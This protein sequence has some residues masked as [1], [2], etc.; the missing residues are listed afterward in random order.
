MVVGSSSWIFVTLG[1]CWKIT[2]GYLRTAS[3]P[4]VASSQLPGGDVSVLGSI[5]TVVIPRGD[6]SHSQSYKDIT[7]S[8]N[9][10]QLRPRSWLIPRT[11]FDCGVLMAPPLPPL[12]PSNLTSFLTLVL[13]SWLPTAGGA[14]SQ[15]PTSS[16]ESL[17]S[18]S[19]QV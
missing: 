7:P 19:T 2:Y 9:F 1:S 14:P 3:P 15:S 11:L 12:L 8:F 6:N 10:H 5:M 16:H 4:M 18:S 17:P 13:T